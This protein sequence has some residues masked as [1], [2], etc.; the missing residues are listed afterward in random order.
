M[1]RLG[2]RHVGRDAQCGRSLLASLFA[3]SDF[4]AIGAWL[5]LAV[6]LIGSVLIA[7]GSVWLGSRIL[8]SD[9]GPEH[10]STLSPFMTVVGPVYGALVGFTVVVGWQQFLTAEVN[11]SNEASTLTTMYRQTV[12][13]PEPQQSQIREQLRK[14]AEGV[15]GPEWGRQDFYRI[16]NTARGAITRMYRLVGVSNPVP[17]PAR[18]ASNFLAN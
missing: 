13:M 10:N 6:V 4:G 16:S 12:A 14:Y 1:V 7:V 11:V 5:L 18:S 17:R 2:R 8:S 3:M 9:T 15:Q